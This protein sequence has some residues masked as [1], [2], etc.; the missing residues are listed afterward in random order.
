VFE[1]ALL[2]MN[3][4]GALHNLNPVDPQSLTGAWFQLSNLYRC[5]ILVSQSFEA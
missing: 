3:E 4:V 5:D 2:S 1:Q